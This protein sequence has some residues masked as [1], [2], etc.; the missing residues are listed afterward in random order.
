MICNRRRKFRPQHRGTCPPDTSSTRAILCQR[1]RCPGGTFHTL[2]FHATTQKCQGHTT[3]TSP[4]APGP[5]TCPSGILFRLRRRPGSSSLGRTGTA[6]CGHCC[7][8]TQCRS[9]L[10]GGLVARSYE[11]NSRNILFRYLCKPATRCRGC[12]SLRGSLYI[13]SS[14]S[15]PDTFLQCNVCTRSRPPCR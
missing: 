12:R 2:F 1:H 9:N 4:A 13:H 11:Q 8:S 6:R 5:G 15:F 14:P 7:S 10:Q 3:C